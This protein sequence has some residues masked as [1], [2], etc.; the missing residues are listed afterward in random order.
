MDG[1]RSGSSTTRKRSSR[2]RAGALRLRRRLRGRGRGG[3]FGQGRE[4][5]LLARRQ[6][7]ELRDASPAARGTVLDL[8]LLAIPAAQLLSRGAGRAE[9]L[10]RRRR[11]QCL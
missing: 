6:A 2:F 5:G 7:F 1:R 11:F 9:I 8:E 4:L 3:G 10:L